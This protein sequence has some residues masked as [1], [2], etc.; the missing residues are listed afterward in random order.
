MSNWTKFDKEFDNEALRDEVKE[1]T[2]NGG[3]GE[4]RE[5]PTGDYEVEI[6][7]LECTSSKKGDPMVTV[8]FNILEGDFEGS[9]IFMNQLI[10][11]GF[12]IHIVNEFLRSLGTDNDVEFKTFSQYEELINKIFDDLDSDGLEYRLKYGKSKKGYPTFEIKEVYD[13]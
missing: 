3:S 12:Q 6:E 7:K 4:Y 13:D 5:V 9:K 2:E 8:W 11:K 10:T 1:A